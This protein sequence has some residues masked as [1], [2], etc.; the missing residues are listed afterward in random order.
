MRKPLRSV[1][2]VFFLLIV[3]LAGGTPPV[4][5]ADVSLRWDANVPAPEG[6]RVFV[7]EAGQ[8]YDYENPIWG[9]SQT[10]CT[11]ISLVEGVT[12][13]FV[14]RAYEG[15]L[16]SADS[17]EVS[18]TPPVVVPNQPP[19]A[20]AGQDLTAVENTRV[21]LDGSGSTDPDGTL[22]S[23][24]WTQT[25]GTPV[26]IDGAAA[27]RA[28]FT[29]PVVGSD[30]ETLTFR[31]TVT[32]D[33][34]TPSIAAV[35]VNVFKSAATDADG[36]QV[37]DVLD[38]FPDNPDA[39]TDH[40]GDGIGDEQDADDDGD[41]MSDVW[42]LA[43]G[44]DPLTDDAAL[45]ADGDGVS[46]L[47]EFQSDTDPTTAPDNAAPDAPAIGDPILAERVNLTPE[48]V[49]GAYF[50][51]DN[52]AHAG[53]RWQIGTDP[54]FSELVLDITSQA[55]LTAYTVGEMVLDADAEY[56]WRVRFI[57]SRH[58]K[59]DWSAP[60]RFT[61]VA[62]DRSGDS[63][64]DGVP[65]AQQVDDA[66]DVNRNGMSDLIEDNLMVVNTVEGQTTVGVETIS[67]NCLLVAVKSLPTDSLADQSVKMGFGLVGFKLYLTEGARTAAVNI[68]FSRQVPE[69]ARLVKYS[70]D[71]G[72]SVYENA[73]FAPDRMSVAMVLE[74][75]GMGDE[76]GIQNGVIVDPTGIAYAQTP[77][78]STD[79]AAL[80]TGGTPLPGSGSSS[81]FISAGS[82]GRIAGQA[83]PWSWALLTTM[84]TVG[85]MAAAFSAKARGVM[86]RL[87]RN[88]HR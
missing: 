10:T 62:A 76:D 13:H 77:F 20:N 24:Q 64:S 88:S 33:D 75:G 45:D 70:A 50:D 61:T 12:Y 19:A 32:D 28:S 54:D 2:K 80:T 37:P 22:T 69:D 65:D 47:L 56:F 57:D 36:D 7:R 52:D 40:D 81:C 14:V 15:D 16:E 46:N 53:S 6:Y 60:A 3:L 85:V 87:G 31:L 84:L 29:A 48:L 4:L 43:Y 86:D 34:G 5:G 42:E 30:G 82:D 39:W 41:G 21:A 25:G 18:Y 26:A 59:S 17:E 51:P 58:G 78:Q 49:C 74:D 63:D 72:W 55:Q 38:Q 23:F 11:L 27:A 8:A 67:E 71:A 79:S 1:L 9:E 44:L 68:H 35:S 73:I 66:V 83:G